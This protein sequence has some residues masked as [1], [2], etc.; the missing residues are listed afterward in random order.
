M[1]IEEY[2]WTV[3]KSI[4]KTALQHYEAF[5]NGCITKA[6]PADHIQQHVMIFY[7]SSSMIKVSK[8]KEDY[9]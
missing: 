9:S 3:E 4:L 8:A 5:C 7:P 1:P 2:G 6:V